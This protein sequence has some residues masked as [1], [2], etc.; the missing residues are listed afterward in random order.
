MNKYIYYYMCIYIITEHG[1]CNRLSWMS[2]LYTWNFLNRCSGDCYVYIKWDKSNACNGHFLEIFNNINF[3][4]WVKNDVEVPK[5]IKRFKGQ[6]SVPNV[7]KMFNMNI[8]TETECMIFNL[9]KFKKDIIEEG[10]K[11]IKNNFGKN[12]IGLHVRRTDHIGLAKKRGNYTSDSYFF[13]LIENMVKKDKNI[14]FYLS[15]DNLKTQEL[16]KKKFGEYIIIRI[17]INKSDNNLRH[18]SLK[19]AGIDLYLLSMCH[20]VEGSFHSSFSRVALMLNLNRRNEIKKADDEL[21]KYI[22]RGYVYT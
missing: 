9:L 1:L 3:L 21:K 17:Q 13:D 6:H 7:F 12:T 10:N 19:D 5:N 20:H 14:K 16:Y 4:K 2:G 18:T 11:Y 8:D 22:F 15:T